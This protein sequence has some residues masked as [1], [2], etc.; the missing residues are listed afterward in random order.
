MKH[1]V[2]FLATIHAKNPD[3]FMFH[4]TNIGVTVFQSEA[5]GIPL[6]SK[7]SDGLKEEEVHDLKI[8]LEGLEI[9][10]VVCGAIAS[11]YQKERVERV[12]KELKL[13][14]LTPMW[15]KDPEELLRDMMKNNFEVVITQVAADGF[16]ESWLGRK[17][18]E[19][20]LKD[21]IRMKYRHKINISAEGGEYESLV[22][23]CPLFSKRIAIMKAEKIWDKDRGIYR[24]ID[25]K[26]SEK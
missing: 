15:G 13:K 2:A 12:C 23:D 18:D 7:E 4:T 25:V 10:G 17:L 21:L 1:D 8:L 19:E 22:L 20:C 24:I 11:K 26:L 16:N 5:L 9:D 14:L 6:V 3:S